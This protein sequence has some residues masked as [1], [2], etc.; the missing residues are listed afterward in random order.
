MLGKKSSEKSAKN[1]FLYS[2]EYR[3]QK[4]GI[5]QRSKQFFQQETNSARKKCWEKNRRK[6]MRKTFF[7]ID[8]NIVT[9]KWAQQNARNNFS[10]NTLIVRAK[11][12]GKKNVGKKCEQGFY[13]F[14]RIS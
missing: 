12:V 8:T 5:T 2:H 9:K 6:K 7:Y 10:I 4:M 13:I 11:N 1:V 3:D 14:K